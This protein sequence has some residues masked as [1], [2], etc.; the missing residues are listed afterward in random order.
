MHE[1]YARMTRLSAVLA[2]NVRIEERKD[3]SDT[4][5]V[6]IS[7]SPNKRNSFSAELEGT[8]SAGDLGAAA[9]LTYQN[10]NLFK[11]SE[12]FNIKLRGAFEAIKGRRSKDHHPICNKYMR[13]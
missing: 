2:S 5:D 4:L 3:G 11:G 13:F 9:S 8:N 7:L 12:L 10:R 1:T 6:S